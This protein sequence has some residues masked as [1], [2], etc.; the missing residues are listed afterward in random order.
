MFKVNSKDIVSIVNFEQIN[1]GWD[2]AT[3]V[4]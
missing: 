1:T 3:N 2:S 4:F